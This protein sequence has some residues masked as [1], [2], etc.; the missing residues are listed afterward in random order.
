MRRRAYA[1]HKLHLVNKLSS[2]TMA[3]TAL[4]IAFAMF[5]SSCSQPAAETTTTVT[6][7]S[8]GEQSDYYDSLE[9]GS[10]GPLR[11]YWSSRRDL[12]PVTDQTY[13]GQAAYKLVYD[14]LL[15]NREDG[16]LTYDL[17]DRIIWTEDGLNLIIMV[18]EGQYFHDGSELQAA[19]AALSLSYLW[20]QNGGP[21]F[22]PDKFIANDQTDDADTQADPDDQTE[23]EQTDPEQD[24]QTEDED[25][26]DNDD[27][28]ESEEY[29]EFPQVRKADE[30]FSL[31]Q[32]IKVIDKYS[33]KCVFSEPAAEF[34]ALLDYFVI[35]S[36]SWQSDDPWQIIPGTGRYRI[37]S[38][39]DN[40]D[41]ILRPVQTSE[42]GPES[43]SGPE[44]IILKQYFDEAEAMRSLEEDKLDLVLL[45]PNS[46]AL[47][48]SRNNLD[49]IR[50]TGLS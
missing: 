26:D 34:A 46:Y 8:P 23:P 32:D 10:S 11:I 27:Q 6:E 12:N 44:R 20:S 16:S 18:K 22:R 50:F 17:A 30:T 5:I 9:R 33:F 38:Y 36:I 21:S 49:L 28:D 24:D 29:I 19:D 47:Y 42:D 48:Y 45:T 2:R 1:T 39:E 41:L 35:P 4:V 7:L 3:L 25:S 13:T 43:D 40:G 37:S 15:T 14:S 31:L